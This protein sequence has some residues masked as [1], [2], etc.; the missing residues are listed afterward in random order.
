MVIKNIH[1]Y[2]NV[3][4]GVT[5]NRGEEEKTHE[6]WWEKKNGRE[7]CAGCFRVTMQK[8]RSPVGNDFTAPVDWNKIKES[9]KTCPK[10]N[11]EEINLCLGFPFS[12]Q[13]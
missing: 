2:P 4:K 3:T 12:Y 8:V 11:A 6:M 9:N 5:N 13:R 1:I 7:I 10:C